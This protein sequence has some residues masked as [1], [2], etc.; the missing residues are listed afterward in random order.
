M[1]TQ[2]TLAFV[3]S[4][5]ASAQ[6][7]PAR[8]IASNEAFN[9]A[10]TA[11]RMVVPEGFSVQVIAGEPDVV[12]P[13]AYAIDDRGR[14]WVLEN[15]N[16]PESPGKPK[17]RILVLEDTDGDGKFEKRT[18]FWDKATFSSGLAVGFGGVWLGSPP[19][20]LFIPDKNG[21]AVPDGEPQIML[22]GWGAEDTHETMNNFT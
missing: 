4:L 8:P 16:Y 21:D 19:N 20:L 7:D 5:L 13:I 1:K 6:S 3:L 14:L 18:V 10:E 9:P 11:S 17:D 15:T 12:Q 22:D 2:F